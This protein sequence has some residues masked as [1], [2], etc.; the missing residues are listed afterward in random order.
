MEYQNIDEVARRE[1]CEKVKQIVKA[2]KAIKMKYYLNFSKISEED[3][4]IYQKL[5]RNL[6]R[7]SNSHDL[8]NL[9][10]AL[11][12]DVSA[13][14]D[15]KELGSKEIGNDKDPQNN[16]ASCCGLVDIEKDALSHG[17]I[18][19]A[20]QCQKLLKE[21][22]KEI[23]SKSYRDLIINYKREK[24]AELG[25]SKEQIATENENYANNIKKFYKIGDAAQRKE[26]KQEVEEAK[27]NSLAMFSK[28]D[29]P[30]IKG[31]VKNVDTK[32]KQEDELQI[33]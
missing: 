33:G 9:K 13:K 7:I 8:N 14:Y 30:I 32:E 16:Y 19:K 31:V 4:E 22:M 2:I 17:Q 10:T 25:K 24:F 6:E 21:Y 29:H 26:A 1:A 12:A 23:D 3:K 11:M 27:S 28:V 15:R 18:I 20:K 5:E